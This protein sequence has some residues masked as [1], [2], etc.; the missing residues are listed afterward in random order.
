[1]KNFID[2][3]Y[4]LNIYNITIREGKYFFYNEKE[5]YIFKMCDNYDILSYYEK[6]K[7]QIDKYNYFFPQLIILIIFL[8]SSTM[9]QYEENHRAAFL[10][11]FNQCRL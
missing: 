11:K 8:I 5:K 3:Y 1:M 9:I 10:R 2:Y 7:H 6:I 4:K